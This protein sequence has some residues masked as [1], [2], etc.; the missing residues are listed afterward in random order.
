MRRKLFS[1]VMWVG[2]AT[3][4][5]IGLAVTLAVVLGIATTALAAA[6][7]DPFRLGKSNAINK[8][9]T[10]VGSTAS[11]ML[12]IDNN[13]A[14]TALDLRV[15]P[16]NSPMTVDSGTQVDNL[17]ADELDGQEASA[18][19]PA[20]GTAT[21]ADKLDGKDSAAFIEGGPSGRGGSATGSAV[22]VNPGA[23]TTIFETPDFRIA[24]QCPGA[25]ITNNN[26]LLRIRNL[27]AQT[28]N[29]FSDNGGTNPNYYGSLAPDA[30][31]DQGAAVGGEFVTFG[32]QGTYVATIQVFSVHRAS[33]NKC[34]VQ[35]QALTTR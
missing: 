20:G 30:V 19:L 18:F 23:F 7:G 1:K 5:T 35:T 13:G 3:V 15:E 9:S 25:D 8:L 14:G 34:H 28:V 27:G 6:P 29:V 12:L 11:S 24:Y 22:A 16:G 32:M 17:N 26:G 31:F 10:L 21:N 4:F 2:R 33:D